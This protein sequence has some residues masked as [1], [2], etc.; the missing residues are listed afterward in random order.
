MLMAEL[1]FNPSAG[2]TSMS[3]INH[4]SVLDD[5]GVQLCQKCKAIMDPGDSASD[6]AGGEDREVGDDEIMRVDINA[7][8]SIISK[9]FK[10][11]E[12]RASKLQTVVPGKMESGSQRRFSKQ[13]KSDKNVFN[14]DQRKENNQ[15]KSKDRNS[16]SNKKKIDIISPI[17]ENAFEEKKHEQKS[18]K[19]FLLDSLTI[20]KFL[21]R[22]Q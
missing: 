21:Q 6:L 4:K 10:M 20:R 18:K 5:H 15:N 14:G 9:V 16:L 13:A 3:R 1:G 19:V 2:I 12:I 22:L 11:R 17:K 8:K 7:N